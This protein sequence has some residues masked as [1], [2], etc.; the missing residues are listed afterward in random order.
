MNEKPLGAHWIRAA[1]QVNPYAY[2]GKNQPSISFSS[3]ADYNKALLDECEALG[4]SLIAVTDHWCVDSAKGL[5]DEATARG[6]V[7]LPG[8]EA[9]SSEGVHILVIFEAD[10]ELSAVNAAIGACGV[11]PQC[12]NGTTGGAFKD[13][14]EAMSDRGALVI[15]AHANVPNSGMLTGRS[16]PPLVARV[17][18]TNLHAVAITP[19]QA[20]GTDQALILSGTKPYNRKHPLA[21]IH[22]DDIVHPDQLKAQGATSWFKV[23]SSRMESLKLA[24]RTP[25]TRVAL[26][27]PSGAP[28]CLLKQIS[29]TGGFL[30]GVTIPI[31]SDLTALIGG[32]GTGKSTVIESLRYALALAPIG[33]DATADHKAIVDKV[34]R[35]G[36]VV[37]VEVEAVFP[38]PHRFTIERVV[39]NPPV[40]RDSAGTAT[41]QKPVDVAGLVEVFGQHEL[42][43]LASCPESVADMLHRFAGTGGSDEAHADALAKLAENR[44]QLKRAET[45]RAKLEAELSDIPRLEE[46][47]Q[48]FKETDVAKRLADL[49]RIGRDESVFSE[50]VQRTETA[51]SALT[52]LADPQLEATLTSNYEGVEDS[53]QKDSLE[54]VIAATSSLAT[55]IKGLVGQAKVAIE[56]AQAEITDA[57]AAWE[58]AVKDERDG[59]AEVLRKLHEEGLEPD[60][61]L[62]TTKALDNL[63]AKEPR[64]ASHDETLRSLKKER[65]RLLGK[66]A[67]HERQKVEDL[68]EAVRSA[69]A[70]TGGIVVVRPIAAPDRSHIMNVINS[71]ISGVRTQITAAVAAKEFSPRAFVEAARAGTVELE[72]LGVKGAQASTVMN[73]GEPLFRQLEE[74]SVGHAVEVLLDISSED[75]PREL[76]TLESLSKGQRATALLLLLLVASTAPL[77]ID[78]PEDDLDNRFVYDGVVANLRKLKGVRQIIASTHNANVPVL[79]DAELI[80]ALEGDGQHGRP[81]TDGI[82]SLDDAPIRALAEDILEGGPAAF[83][84]RQ[85]LYGF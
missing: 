68:H 77:V 12:E 69:N 34:L 3:E 85:H 70:A 37:K 17:K 59:H 15:P 79:G 45:A 35:S 40:V 28:R 19:S 39:P 14:L 44:E 32:R 53:P 61:Y 76:K 75:G 4:I 49:Q 84:A 60:K 51:T 10:A 27:D 55:A 71:H 5:I 56:A 20:D 25:E 2:K 33:K 22:A 81:I 29:W 47:A 58:G 21:I 1:L 74:L 13:I 36:T 8:F 65:D 9:N 64:L 26:N 67:D 78:Q 11:L 6:I 7:A 62:D 41:N 63:K 16:G 30:D 18:D 46:K 80:V 72:K 52:D 50:A 23:S 83:N 42:A 66:L 54:R 24:V 43:E 38:T 73:A 82:G 57:K 48:Q 31:S